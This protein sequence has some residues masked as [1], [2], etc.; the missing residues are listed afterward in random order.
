MNLLIALHELSEALTGV[1]RVSR[2]EAWLRLAQNVLIKRGVE[3]LR[4]E[5]PANPTLATVIRAAAIESQTTARRAF[6]VL[7]VH[8][9]AVRGLVSSGPT[10]DVCTFIERALPDVLLRFEY[11]FGG[12]TYEKYHV[13]GRLHVKIDELLVPFEPTFPNWQGLYAG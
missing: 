3:A 12:S 5:L 1:D 9:L 8:A 13:L 10:A 7:V 4:V 6:A 2:P 11:P